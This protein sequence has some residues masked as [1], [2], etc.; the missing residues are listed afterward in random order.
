MLLKDC[1]GVY[2]AFQKLSDINLPLKSSWM[3]AQNINKL[4][5]LVDTFEET[6]QKYIS[7]LREKATLDADGQP[8]VSDDLA[9]EFR[10]SVE[11]LLNEDQKV[12]LKKV[13]LID[14]GELSI[15]P[16]VLLAAMD[17]LI[18]KEDGNK[19]G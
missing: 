4:Q 14:T 8:E 9:N 3:I 2:S 7:N 12:R 16:S 13:T 10:E 11:T 15:E 18:L 5:P 19:A 1:I 6:R 17:Y